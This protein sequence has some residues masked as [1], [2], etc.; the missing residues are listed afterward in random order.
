MNKIDD[1]YRTIMIAAF[2]LVVHISLKRDMLMRSRT[3]D[4]LTKTVQGLSFFAALA[5]MGCAL[6]RFRAAYALQMTAP[7]EMKSEKNMMLALFMCVIL[8]HI[9]QFYL[10]APFSLSP[11][12]K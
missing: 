11:K 4:T 9:I 10:S 8:A 6:M 2:G 3:N 1:A 7:G 5:T 12:K